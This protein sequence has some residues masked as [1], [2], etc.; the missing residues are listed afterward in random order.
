MSLT[1]ALVDLEEVIA[2]GVAAQVARHAPDVKVV[3][4]RRGVPA[5][6]DLALHDPVTREGE[7]HA[8]AGRLATDPLV[9][10]VVAFS[11][12]VD[13]I[14]VTT[15]AARG[16]DAAL[17]ARLP[18][19]LLVASLLQVHHGRLTLHAAPSGRRG[20][21]WPG[22]EQGLTVRES[23]VL[24]LIAGGLSNHEISVQLNLSI[25]SVKSYIRSAYRTIDVDSR[26]KAVLW[27]ITHGLRTP[28]APTERAR[29]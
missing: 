29:R 25:N 12:D 15:L 1:V 22:R 27:G 19:Q 16:Y 8:G 26:T 5:R 17:S 21:D 11:W 10:R 7:P 24:S 4:L 2:F 6:V 3:G 18:G 20:A 28:G 13:R 23:D 9:G 14:P